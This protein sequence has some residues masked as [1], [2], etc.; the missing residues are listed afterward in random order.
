VTGAY[1]QRDLH[2]DLS[3]ERLGLLAEQEQFLRAHGFLESPVQVS[4]WADHAP[5]HAALQESSQ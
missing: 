3:P 1:R 4:A 2:V 5:L